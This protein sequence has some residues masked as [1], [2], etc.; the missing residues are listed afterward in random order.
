MSVPSS[1]S[2]PTS[3][4]LRTTESVIW[5]VGTT[6]SASASKVKTRAVRPRRP[7]N[8]AVSLPNRGASATAMMTP[9]MMGMMKGSKILMHHTTSA[10]MSAKRMATSTE[11]STAFFF[12]DSEA[13]SDIAAPLL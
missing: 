9:H 3:I 7:P 5:N 13:V 2:C 12:S 6:T 10:A 8:S 4:E 11:I 1:N